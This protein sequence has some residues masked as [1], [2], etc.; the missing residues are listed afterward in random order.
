MIQRTSVK[1][2]FS[3]P[4][5]SHIQ[6]FIPTFF[7]KYVAEVLLDQKPV[8]LV[9]FDTAGQEDYEHLRPQVYTD[10]HVVLLAFGVD[11]TNSLGNGKEKISLCPH[12]HHSLF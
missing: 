7:E 9:L 5:Y 6:I 11:S 12:V 3:W 2:L 10:C 8:R 1:A 4:S